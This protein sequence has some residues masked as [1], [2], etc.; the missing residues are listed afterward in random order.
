MASLGRSSAVFAVMTLLSR[1]LGLLR[2]ML[3]ARYFDAMVT[4]AFYAALRIPNT[5][6]RRDYHAGGKRP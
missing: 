3:V 1:V 5:L 4:D 2:D 6:R